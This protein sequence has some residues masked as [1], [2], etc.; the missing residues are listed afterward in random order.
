MAGRERPRIIAVTAN[1]LRE[2]R[3][4]CLAAG[5]DDFL[6]KPVLLEDLRLV[7]GQMTAGTASEPC[8]GQEVR[9]LT[10]GSCEILPAFCLLSAFAHQPM[11]RPLPWPIV[12]RNRMR[13]SRSSIRPA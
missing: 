5:M 13:C 4:T 8:P 1:A 7:L 9:L 11:P 2:D 10:L 3:E 6:S 12:W